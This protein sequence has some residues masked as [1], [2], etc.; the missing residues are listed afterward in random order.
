MTTNK[1]SLASLAKAAFNPVAKLCNSEK[2]DER[3]VGI[4]IILFIFC[5]AL[6]GTTQ[7]LTDLNSIGLVAYLVVFG[8]FA[9]IISLAYRPAL[10]AIAGFVNRDIFALK[11]S[12]GVMFILSGLSFYAAYYLRKDLLPL[13]IFGIIAQLMSIV[14]IGFAKIPI[15]TFQTQSKETNKLTF[16][17][18]LE[19]IDTIGGVIGLI[20]FLI[21]FISGIIT[22]L[23]SLL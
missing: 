4:N 22:Y 19:K 11:F 13:L 14:I 7:Q 10:L 6:V 20:I 3:L 16:W 12:V 17:E 9:S 18:I 5:L 15:K 23:F 8:L 2:D 21:P 1:Q